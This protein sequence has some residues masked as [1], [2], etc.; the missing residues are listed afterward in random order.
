[1]PCKD[2]TH[3]NFSIQTHFFP[4]LFTGKVGDWKNYFTVAQSEM[5]DKFIEVD[6]VDI[7]YK[8]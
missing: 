4:S 1:M 8:F 7:D 6:F 5:Y 2:L 3:S